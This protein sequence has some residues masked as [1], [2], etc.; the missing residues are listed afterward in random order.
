MKQSLKILLGFLLVGSMLV[1]CEKKDDN[2]NGSESKTNYFMV[3]SDEYTLSAGVL[4]NYGEATDTD[5]EYDGYNIDLTLVSNGISVSLDS[6]GFIEAAGTGHLLYFEMF[7]TG[8]EQLDNGE[9]VYDE[10]SLAIKTFDYA[11]YA[12]NYNVDSEDESEEE[13]W[14]EIVSGKVTV[15]KTGANYSIDIDCKDDSGKVIKGNYT[16]TLLYSDVSDDMK[17]SDLYKSKKVLLK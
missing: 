5:W 17:A 14:V 12:L 11:D 13:K 7:T 15:N 16:G 6:D 1:S 4:E 10:N 9:F 2:D 8:A 3:G